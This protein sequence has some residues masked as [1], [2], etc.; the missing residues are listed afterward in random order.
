MAKKKS[1][2][3][4]LDS[5]APQDLM[6][7]LLSKS[8][9]VRSFL[10]G[11]KVTATVVQIGDKILML[12]IGAKSEGIVSDTEF[13]LA[14][15]YIKSLKPGDK[16][17]ATVTSPENSSGQVRLSIREGAQSIGW[18]ELGKAKLENRNIDAY[19]LEASR[20]GVTVSVFGIESFIS[21]SQLG[22]KVN[23]N[24]SQ[25]SGHNLMVKVLAVDQKNQKLVLSE[26]AISEADLLSAQEEALKKV[27]VGE[28]FLGKVQ[29]I[30]NFGA[31]IQIM[32]GE[33]PID[34]LVH[35]SELSWERISDVSQVLTLG[36][37]VEVCIIG[38]DNSGGKQGTGRLALSIKQTQKDPWEESLGNLKS[39]TKTRGKVLKTG[40]YGAVIELKPGI[41]GRVALNKIPD[42]VSLREGDL[43]DVF[44]EALDKR[45]RS[46]SL[47]LVLTTKPVGY[48]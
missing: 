7:Q 16:V 30:T 21:S 12:D 19:V 15:F 38:K 34:G 46:I 1:A 6:A 24:L 47:G 9:K 40:D 37:V 20:G 2:I 39:D 17:S 22:G 28:K 43:L 29:A 10:L 8:T 11:E 35:L 4:T 41:E 42:G 18:K 45:K 13:E 14:S 26:K 44:I 31:F 25:I 23:K 3:P 27:K 33:M 32:I 5:R 36:Q 48:K